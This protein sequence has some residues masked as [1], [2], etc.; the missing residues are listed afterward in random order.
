MPSKGDVALPE[1]TDRGETY[2]RNPL[3]SEDSDPVRSPDDPST[4][5]SGQAQEFSSSQ[6]GMDRLLPSPDDDRTDKKGTLTAKQPTHQEAASNDIDVGNYYVR[7]KN[8][9]AALSRFQSAMVLDPDN[10]EVFW[11]LAETER[12]LGDLADA[13]THYQK[14]VD[15]DPDSR[16]GKDARK[17]LKDP[18]IANAQSAAHPPPVDSPK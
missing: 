5:D 8:W 14:V 7:T 12:H 9:R 2:T 1:G 17:A 13:R 10:P 3:P 6:Q 18:E 15:Y 16:H 4:S 11:G